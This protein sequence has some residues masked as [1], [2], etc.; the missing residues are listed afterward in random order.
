MVQLAAETQKTHCVSSMPRTSAVFIPNTL[1]TNDRGRKMM[2][3][4]VKTTVALSRQSCTLDIWARACDYLRQKDIIKKRRC[5]Y[6]RCNPYLALKAVQ[7]AAKLLDD[8]VLDLN[9]SGE[10]GEYSPPWMWIAGDRIT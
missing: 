1:A 4:M 7:H 2:V 6:S 9:S 8:I 5:L 3:M 10:C